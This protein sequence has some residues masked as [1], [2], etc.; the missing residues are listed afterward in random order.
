MSMEEIETVETG[1]VKG[2]AGEWVVI[3]ADKVIARGFD[4]KEMF[5]I[6]E[7]YKDQ[8]VEVVKVLHPQA[9]YY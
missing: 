5:R 3:L 7:K 6:A 9:S 4:V 2:K 8:D 1:G